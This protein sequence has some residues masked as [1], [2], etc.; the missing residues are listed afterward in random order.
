MMDASRATAAMDFRPAAA[1]TRASNGLGLFFAPGLRP[2]RDSAPPCGCEISPRPLVALTN[3]DSN[4][5]AWMNGD[6]FGI[7]SQPSRA[8]LKLSTTLDCCTTMATASRRTIHRP[9][10]GIG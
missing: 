5:R 1:C 6:S 3:G 9:S 10:V 2:P 4:I 8:R 7:G